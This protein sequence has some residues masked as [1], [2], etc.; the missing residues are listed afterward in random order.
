MESTPQWGKKTLS[1]STAKAFLRKD[2]KGGNWWIK[3]SQP[4]EAGV[5]NV[6]GEGPEMGKSLVCYKN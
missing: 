6:L 4:Q 3:R 2:M 1:K 5:E